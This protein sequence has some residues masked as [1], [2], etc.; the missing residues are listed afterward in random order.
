MGNLL[1]YL[2]VIKQFEWVD[3]G[4]SPLKLLAQAEEQVCD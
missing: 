2:R 4:F 3:Q 1:A